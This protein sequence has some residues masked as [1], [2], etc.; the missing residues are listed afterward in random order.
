MLF[1]ENLN[2]VYLI[3]SLLLGISIR[4]IYLTFKDNLSY[5]IGLLYLI[6]LFLF[7]TIDIYRTYTFRILSE[8]LGL[9]TISCFFYFFKQKLKHKKLM[10]EYLALVML[11]ISI[12]IRPNL[13]IFGYIYVIFLVYYSQKMKIYNLKTLVIM[14]ALFLLGVSII[15]IRNYII[16]NEIVFFPKEGIDYA[17]QVHNVSNYL[18]KTLYCFG[19]LTIYMPEYKVRPHWVIMW[20]GILIY[21]T[22]IIKNNIKT[23]N[24]SNITFLFTSVY[25]VTSII[26]VK[27]GSYGYRIFLPVILIVLIYPF[28]LL[29]YIIQKI[30]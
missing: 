25:Y 30:N 24:L 29:D 2:P 3:Q 28:Y 26:F 11:V 15:A 20:F 13:I 6:F 17:N 7:A 12:L 4:L 16:C 10:Y 19:Y 22:I 21:L 27:V 23:D 18:K 14:I 5:K 9:F 8:N 1:G